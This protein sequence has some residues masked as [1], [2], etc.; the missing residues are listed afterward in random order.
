MSE[1]I[2]WFGGECPVSPD[3]LV[4]TWNRRGKVLNSKASKRNWKWDGSGND[5]VAYQ[6]VDESIYKDMSHKI[7]GSQRERDA[8]RDEEGN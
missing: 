6:L 7:L 5:I 3:K 1:W 2:D 8:M 4:Y